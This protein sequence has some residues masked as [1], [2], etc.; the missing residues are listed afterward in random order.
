M[1]PDE[2]RR[3]AWSG[4]LDEALAAL[5]EA[6][7]AEPRDHLA[8]ARVDQELA[9]PALAEAEYALAGAEPEGLEIAEPDAPPPEAAPVQPEDAD[10]ARF[11]HLF[12]GREG[13]HARQWYE[14][15]RGGGYS[16]VRAPLT[17]ELVRAHLAG[18]VTLGAYTLRL[19]DTVTWFCLD[20]DIR[21]KALEAA[22]DDVHRRAH[23]E[24]R[25]RE[26]CEAIQVGLERLRLPAIV[27]DSGFKGRH[28]WGL[29]AEPLPA[30]LV[31]RFGKRLLRALRPAAPELNLEFFPKQGHVPPGGVGNLVKLPLG[32]HRRSGRR[33]AFLDASQAPCTD[34][35][36]RLRA[37]PK[38]DR[39][40]LLA[41]FT[42][43]RDAPEAPDDTLPDPPEQNGPPDLRAAAEI[44][45]G[46]P[47]L[48]SLTDK[49]AGERR[50]SH[51]EQIVLIHTLGHLPEVIEGLNALFA[52]CPEVPP[53]NHVQRPLRGHPIS[54]A[55]IRA[56]VPQLTSGLPCHCDFG[57]LRGHYPTPLLH[58]GPR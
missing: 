43:L 49:A 58:L 19:D 23:L 29:L 15:G 8:W 41:A 33:S 3:L 37:A 11:V 21:R 56:R 51:D 26:A 28:F 9:Q 54:C 12:G 34:P 10:L 50:A 40:A 6:L 30:E 45:T 42:A 17:V 20:L 22:G 16:P 44:L 5:R 18:K 2:V 4:R 31:H 39:G 7:Q 36:A 48:Q 35:W 25:M 13:V 57:D 24:Q 14:P 52:W 46:C 1:S 55:K 53:R 27:E 32:V 47:V 38:L